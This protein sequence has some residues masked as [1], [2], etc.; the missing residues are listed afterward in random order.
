M[1]VY[2][3]RDRLAYIFVCSKCNPV[4]TSDRYNTKSEAKNAEK[5]HVKRKH[6]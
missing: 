3:T 6:K 1:A 5:E 2:E 4:L